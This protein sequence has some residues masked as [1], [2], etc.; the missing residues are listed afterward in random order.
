[1]RG[2]NC[3]FIGFLDGNLNYRSMHIS[4]QQFSRVAFPE[5]LLFDTFSGTTIYRKVEALAKRGYENDPAIITAKILMRQNIVSGQ[6]ET[7]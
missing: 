7:K 4:K 6:L 1:S 5:Q 3:K 2:K